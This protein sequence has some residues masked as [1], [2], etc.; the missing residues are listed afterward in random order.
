M[1]SQTRSQRR[2]PSAAETAAST[3][4]TVGAIGWKSVARNAC[5]VANPRHADEGP[6]AGPHRPIGRPHRTADDRWSRTRYAVADPVGGCS[7]GTGEPEVWS[8]PT[9]WSDAG[10]QP[11]PGKELS[12]LHQH[13]IRSAAR[14]LPGMGQALNRASGA[15]RVVTTLATVADYREAQCTSPKPGKVR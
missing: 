15:E 5:Q 7:G 1:R 2:T 8:R 9:R 14:L 11:T 3:L 13:R 4:R 6:Y 12:R 10:S